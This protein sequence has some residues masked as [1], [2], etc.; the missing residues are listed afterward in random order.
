[1]S[2]EITGEAVRLAQAAGEGA[3]LWHP[4]D[5]GYGFDQPITDDAARVILAAAAPAILESRV[6]AVARAM[7]ERWREGREA[8]S[9]LV[10]EVPMWERAEARTRERFLG[11]AGAALGLSD[12][13]EGE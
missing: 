12:T 10:A 7:Y 2:V 4:T 11:Y 13:G 3:R 5:D 1:M 6:E 8:D 9:E